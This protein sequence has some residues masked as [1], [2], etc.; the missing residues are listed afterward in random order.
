DYEDL[1]ET[2]RIHRDVPPIVFANFGTTMKEAVDQVRE[3]RKIFQDLAIP[4][5]YIH[6]DGALAGMTLPFLEE[7]PPFDFEEG[8]DSLSISGHKFIGSPIPCGVVLAKKDHVRMIARSIEYV[9]TLDTTVP[10]SRNGFTPLLLWYAVRRWGKEGFRSRVKECVEKA[11]YAVD[12]FRRAGIPAWRNPSA[13]TVV[14]PRPTEAIARRW[15]IAV[16]DEIGHLICMPSL[17]KEDIDRFIQ[18]M[19]GGP[20]FLHEEEAA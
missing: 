14:I 11:K 7:A 20:P 6:G 4:K 5:A 18:E 13:I 9:G 19:L 2:I 3:I 8:I 16:E 1:R 15:Q 10:G 17:R 12:Q